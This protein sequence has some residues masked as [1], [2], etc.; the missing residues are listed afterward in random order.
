MSTGDLAGAPGR[1]EVAG[2]V[3]DV[4]DPEPIP[5]DHPILSATNVLLT[6]HLAARTTAG[7]ACMNDVVDDVVAVLQGH[8]PRYPA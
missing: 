6:P 2:A 1:G 7:L 5:P 8:R 3:L 4:H